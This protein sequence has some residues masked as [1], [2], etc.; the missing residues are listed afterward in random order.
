LEDVIGEDAGPQWLRTP[1]PGLR[2]EAPIDLM[3]SNHLEDV[4]A[5]LEVLADGG[6]V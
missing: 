4:V 2:G 3:T 6:P 5:V 1:N